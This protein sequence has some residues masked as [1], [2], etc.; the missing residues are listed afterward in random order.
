[1]RTILKDEPNVRCWVKFRG[2][3]V[4]SWGMLSE[5]YWFPKLTYMTFTRRS[6]RCKGYGGEVFAVAREWKAT[7]CE[8]YHY[9]DVD[10]VW[11]HNASVAAKRFFR[12]RSM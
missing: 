5:T 6:E 9:K 11:F 1:M 8:A 3:K 12:G 10:V 4:V 7:D 2:K